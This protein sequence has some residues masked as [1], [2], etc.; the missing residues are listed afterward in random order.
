M[1]IVG[2]TCVL[3]RDILYRAAAD[4]GVTIEKVIRYSMPGL[5]EYHK[6]D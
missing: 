6:N 2:S 1:S 3:Y 5:V 4:F